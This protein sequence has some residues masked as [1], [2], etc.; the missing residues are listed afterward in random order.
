[1]SI[2]DYKETKA[3]KDGSMLKKRIKNREGISYEP[4]GHLTDTMKDFIVQAFKQ[5]YLNYQNKGAILRPFGI[6]QVKRSMYKLG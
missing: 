3:D 1:M 5:E 6:S 2:K 4:N